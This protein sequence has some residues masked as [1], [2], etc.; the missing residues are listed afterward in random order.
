MD[1]ASDVR[2]IHEEAIVVDAH[3][4]TIVAHMRLGLG[5]TF[6]TDKL[7][8]DLPRMREG[9]L[10]V[11]FFA[12][13]VTRATKSHLTYALDAL[14]F[15]EGELSSSENLIAPIL[16]VRDLIE[17]T[18]QG[19]IGALLAIENSD[20]LEGSLYVLRALFKLGI[21]SI[22]LTHNPRSL[23]ADGVDEART[24]G[25]LTN[26]GIRLVEEMNRLG[27]LVD[28]AHVSE[29]G[30]WE[31]LDLSKKPVIVSHA[32]CKALC[33]H[34]RNLNDEQIRGLADK[35]GVLG[36]SFVPSFID[37][38]SPSL[39]RL[40]D[41]VD[42]VV[43]IAGIEFVGLGSDFDGGGTLLKDVTVLPEVTKGLFER[44]YTEEEV[45]KILGENFIRV[46]SK[47]LPNP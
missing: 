8:L 28:L 30:F 14:G 43:K 18:N 37:P 4:D 44:G 40:L 3:N 41:H 32:N 13:D 21:R 26:F 24:G 9:G 29:R 45:K 1:P 20:A 12:I 42:H 6:R 33:D 35:G 39:Q 47:V 23:A 27:I 34:K 22:G 36:L 10:D 7:Q 15:L 31:A 17:I 5:L 16:R 19:K 25:G 11:A 46:L 2:R 38:G